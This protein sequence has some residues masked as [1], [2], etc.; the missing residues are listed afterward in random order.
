[1]TVRAVVDP[2]ASLTETGTETDEV[3]ETRDYYPF[4]PGCPG[5]A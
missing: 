3:V 5:E 1:M 2:D 4:C